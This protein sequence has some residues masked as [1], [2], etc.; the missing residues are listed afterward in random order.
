MFVQLK[1]SCPW[2]VLLGNSISQ[3]VNN[4]LGFICDEN[5]LKKVNYTVFK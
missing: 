4:F 2:K 5:K 3:E 1:I